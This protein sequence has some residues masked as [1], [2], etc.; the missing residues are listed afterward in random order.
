MG[1][2]A[3]AGDQDLAGDDGHGAAAAQA[4]GQLDVLHERLIGE[5]AHVLEDGAAHEHGLIAVGDAAESR[6][7]VGE[8]E[9]RRQA[10]GRAGAVVRRVAAEGAGDDA[11]ARRGS[12][13]SR[14]RRRAGPGRRRARRPGS[15]RARRR[16]PRRAGGRGRAGRPRPR[17]HDRAAIAT[18]SSR[19]PPSATT[20]PPIPPR[21]RASSVAAM[22]ASSSS[23]GTTAAM[24]TSRRA[25]AVTWRRAPRRCAAHARAR[26]RAGWRAGADPRRDRH[27][28]SA[29]ASP[30]SGRDRP[31]AATPRRR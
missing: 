21:R 20:I 10:R 15:R 26:S 11:G 6:A 27:R 7:D 2:E 17:P 8:T 22:R 1:D 25:S 18:V 16:R 13:G 9:P 31:V 23:V 4:A 14:R 19:E 24:V 30:C 3:A 5:A 12:R 28:T 29:A